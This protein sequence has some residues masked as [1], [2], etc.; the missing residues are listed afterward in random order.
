MPLVNQTIVAVKNHSLPS[1]FLRRDVRI[2]C[3]TPSMPVKQDEM[4][5]LL[6]NDGQDMEELGLAD[7]LTGLYRQNNIRPVLCVGIYCGEDRRNEYGTAA[8]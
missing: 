2:D 6:I 1:R 7:L 5:L 3:F 4:S 8:V